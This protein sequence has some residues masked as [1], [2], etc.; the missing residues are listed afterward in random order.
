MNALTAE[1]E[2]GNEAPTALYRFFDA[3]GALLY[4]GIT[5]CLGRRFRQHARRVSWWRAIARRTVILYATRA[6]ALSAEDW[7]ILSERPVHNVKGNSARRV[8]LPGMTG[9][10]WYSRAA[11]RRRLQNGATIRCLREKDGYSQGALAEVLD[12]TQGGL[13]RIESEDAGATPEMLSKIAR[14]LCVSVDAIAR[15][16]AA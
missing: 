8:G 15:E 3:D 16:P 11:G 1:I 7:A 12:I 14:H 6:A 2:I 4:V 5:D 9:I 10:P 13:S